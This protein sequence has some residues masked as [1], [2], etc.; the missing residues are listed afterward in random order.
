M[1]DLEKSKHAHFS[2]QRNS[3]EI[4]FQQAYDDAKEWWNDTRNIVVQQNVSHRNVNNLRQK[5]WSRP[6]VEWLKYNVD[7]SF[8]NDAIPG[9]VGWVIRDNWGVYK[10]AVQATRKQVKN[11]LE[12]E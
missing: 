2:E 3:L 9:Q 10:G 12:C 1:K 8:L 6:P 5:P 11:A 7:E 4:N